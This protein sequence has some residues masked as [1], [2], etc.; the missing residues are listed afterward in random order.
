MRR[1][2]ILNILLHITIW[3]IYIV[4]PI[5]VIPLSSEYLLAN[6]IR[7]TI[8]LTNSALLILFFYLNF[9]IF[10]PKLYFQKKYLWFVISIF[11]LLISFVLITRLVVSII[12]PENLIL[13]RQNLLF[14]NYFSQFILIFVVSLLL[15]YRERYKRIEQEKTSAELDALK[16]Q[17]NPHFLFNTLNDIY[18]LALTKSNK[19]ADSISKL[20]FMMRYVLTQANS[21]K[22]PLQDEIKH[23][24]TFVELQKIR[25]T[26]KTKIN[27]DVKG[28]ITSR[29]IQPLLFI[30]F[31]ENAFKY[32]VSNEHETQI[33]IQISL[34]GDVLHFSI[35]NDKIIKNSRI[36]NNIGLENIRKRLNLI[37]GDNSI[38][39][40]NETD[41]IFMVS[42]TINNL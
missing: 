6:D 41:N 26:G 7:L 15:S 1:K 23:L 19:T 10:L 4:L 42:L 28:N 17:L 25:L 35:T 33:N 21:E 37:Y 32:G 24:Q 27:F 11:S 16:S 34:N 13:E 40:I 39:K 30:N 22:V 31:V 18:G 8:Y 9:N 38:L 20:S 36:S 29:Q 14:R 3:S 5:F 2:K 12:H